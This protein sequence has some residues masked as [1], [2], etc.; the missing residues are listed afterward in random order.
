MAGNT[1]KCSAVKRSRS[2]SGRHQ[3]AQR[4][5]VR[6]HPAGAALVLG[7]D[8]MSFSSHGKRQFDVAPSGGRG[9]QAVVRL[10]DL[11]VGQ[12]LVERD[13]YASDRRIKLCN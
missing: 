2:S 11:L 12:G 3:D 13:T 7:V 8:G 10:L 6:A 5:G 1:M 9:R 4:V